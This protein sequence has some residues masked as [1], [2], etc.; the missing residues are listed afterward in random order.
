M[1]ASRMRGARRIAEPE[2]ASS[3]AGA[4]PRG[5]APAVAAEHRGLVE[6]R[7]ETNVTMD[8]EDS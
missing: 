5:R 3:R 2:V 7:A 8:A 6:G 4:R 1:N